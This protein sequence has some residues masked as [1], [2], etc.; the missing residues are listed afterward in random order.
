[1][2]Q[3]I[4]QLTDKYG[5]TAEQ[6]TGIMATIKEYAE[7]KVPGLGNSLDSILQETTDV[8]PESSNEKQEGF[9]EKATHYVEDHIP[10][11][12]KEKTEEVLEG[13]GTKIKNLFN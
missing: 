2:Q 10:G 4:K 1:M 11:G 3:L 6:A 7:Q 12:L 5:I 9:F 13:V 8:S